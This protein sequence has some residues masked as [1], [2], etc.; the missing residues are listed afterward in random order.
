ML[1]KFSRRQWCTLAIMALADFCNAICVSLQAPFFP[2]EAEKKGAVATEY[3]LVFGIFELV[4]FVVSPLYGQYLDKFGPKLLFNAGI[5]TTGSAA[6]LFGMLDRIPDHYTFIGL[7]FTIRIIEA[8]GNAAFLTASFAIIA[9]EFP[10]NVATTFACLETCFGVGLIVGPMVGGF[11]YSIDGYYLPFVVLGSALFFTALLTICTLP[12]HTSSNQTSSK[13][14][15]LTVLRIPGVMVSALAITAASCSIGFISATL[16]PHLRTF[17]LSPVLLGM[18]FV[19]NGGVYALTAPLYGWLVDNILKPKILTILGSFFIAV[20]FAL[21][22][23]APFIPVP[24][25]LPMVIAG[26][27]FHG[28][29]IGACLVSTFSDALSTSVKEG[30]PNSIETYGLISG[31]WT[32]TFAFGA[33]VGPSVS[34]VLFDSI[35]FQYSTLFI[36]GLQVLIIIVI[37]TFVCITNY[38]FKADKDKETEPLLDNEGQPNGK[39]SPFTKANENIIQETLLVPN[40]N[41]I[42]IDHCRPCGMA[43][44]LLTCNSY[45]NKHHNWASAY[46]LESGS[47]HNLSFR[48]N[49]GSVEHPAPSVHRDYETIS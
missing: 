36:I 25:T 14:S 4:V 34:G 8:L 26:L 1:N 11:L 40:G 46:R 2:A 37:L 17:D 49:Y 48:S 32:S 20:G 13:L 28:F 27:V 5:F 19:I 38:G 33:F 12:K 7:A 29:G 6:I 15:M 10:D 3:G 22:G 16:E 30:L 42:R 45:N 39:I 47:S 24:T 41:T 18:I 43:N 23:P 21:V 44:N 35:G 9:K 31:L